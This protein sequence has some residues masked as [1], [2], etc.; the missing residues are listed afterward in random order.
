MASLN[1]YTNYL[2]VQNLME[3]NYQ[4]VDLDSINNA[5]VVYSFHVS[6]LQT[7]IAT[8]CAHSSFRVLDL[9]LEV[10]NTLRLISNLS[11]INKS[12][13]RININ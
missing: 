5:G 6:K 8:Y 2:E 12:S 3:P 7:Y 10:K 11:S 9:Y 4:L 13:I 1:Q